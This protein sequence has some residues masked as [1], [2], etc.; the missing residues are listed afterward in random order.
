MI[1]WPKLEIWK[2]CWVVCHFKLYLL[3]FRTVV[4]HQ[5]PENYFSQIWNTHSLF[6]WPL[7]TRIAPISP[8]SQSTFSSESLNFTII[9]ITTSP[10]AQKYPLSLSFVASLNS[11]LQFQRALSFYW[12]FPTCKKR[13]MSLQAQLQEKENWKSQFLGKSFR[14]FLCVKIYST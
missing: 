6:L 9:P 7:S 4:L 13:N 11:N 1:F 2:I 8:K 10:V 5:N 12:I 3:V 14:H